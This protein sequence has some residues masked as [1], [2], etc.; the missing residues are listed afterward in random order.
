[1]EGPHRDPLWP[2]LIPWPREIRVPP[3]GDYPSA[4]PAALGA[5]C[6]P[7]R[8]RRD[9]AGRIGRR[10]GEAVGKVERGESVKGRAERARRNRGGRARQRADAGEVLRLVVGHQQVRAAHPL[11]LHSQR[12]LA[13]SALPSA[14]VVTRPLLGSPTNFADRLTGAPTSSQSTALTPETQRTPPDSVCSGQGSRVLGF[15]VGPGLQPR[16][17]GT[18]A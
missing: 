3:A 15:K 9:G 5:V 18:W 1:M 2:S 11:H 16:P 6:A 8:G 7:A 4:T 14:R 12:P 13:P 10:A 17:N